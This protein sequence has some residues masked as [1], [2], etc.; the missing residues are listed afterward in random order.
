MPL[1][2]QK[3]QPTLDI[4]T[5]KVLLYGPPKIGKTTLAAGLDPDHTLLI[6]TEKGY[7]AL[8]AFVQPINTWAEF[9]QIGPDLHDGDHH[10]RTLVIDT[11]DEL[12][13]FCTEQVMK[14]LGIKH[15]SDLEYGKGWGAVTDEF[16]L[17]VGALCSLGLGVWFVSH[18]KDEEIKQRI[19]SITVTSPTLSGGPRKW[20][21]GFVDFIF[22]ARSEVH[23]DGEVR[24]LRTTATENF[25]AGGRVPLPDPILLEAGALREALTEASPKPAAKVD[26]AKSVTAAAESLAADEQA[27]LE[28]QAA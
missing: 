7:G 20:L 16:R 10:F 24:V 27:E 17:R 8:E 21:M 5:A 6:A 1:P 11:V 12:F 22:L 18:A 2:T 28:P 14:D 15:P 3:M 26:K 23:E 4:E 13:K 25:E 9:R 19:G